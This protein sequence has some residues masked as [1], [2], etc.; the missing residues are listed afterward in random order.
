MQAGETNIPGFVDLQVN[1]YKRID[2]SS[3]SLTPEDVYRVTSMLVEAGTIVYLPTMVTCQMEIYERNLRIFA[4]VLKDK[5]IRQHIP[6]IHLEGPFISPLD[7]ARG[8]HP[9]ECIQKPS[10]EVLKKFQDW[11]E[12]NIK[13]ITLAPEIEGAIEIIRYA[14]KDSILVSLGHHLADD[15]AMDAAVKA[16]ASLATHLGNGLPGMINRHQNPLWWELACDELYG[17][18]I[19]DG[20][21]LPDDYIKVALRAKKSHRFL[22]VSDM[23]DLAGMPPG[24]YEFHGA[25]VTLAPSGR[26]SLADT[27]YLAGSSAVMI[28]CMNKLASLNVLSKKELIKIGFFAPLKLLKIKPETILNES[29][30]KCLSYVD[31]QFR[32]EV[33]N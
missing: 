27:P 30:K 1:G 18:F 21:H 28:Q 23:S 20:H 19:T 5:N 4:E 22:V 12:G 29:S 14:I 15:E 10:I 6:G 26:I 9:L 17:M 8:A 3:A 31:G 16:G 2:F 24:R 7:G 25:P 32:Q 11:S 33:A 13:L